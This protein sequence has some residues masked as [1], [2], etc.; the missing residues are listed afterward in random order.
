MVG[1]RDTPPSIN[2][3]PDYST[4]ARGNHD[5]NK[6][7]ATGIISKDDNYIKMLARECWDSSTN[8]LNAG[9][10]IAWNDS[11]RAFQGQHT[12]NSKYLSTDYRYRSR[13]FRPKTRSM[14]RKAEA[15]A[16][17]AFFGNEDV[18]SITPTD[19]DNPLQRASA[20]ILKSLVQYRLTKTIPW[21]LTLV[22]GRQDAEVMGIAIAKAYW[23]FA[24]KYSSTI[25]KPQIDLLTGQPMVDPE[26]GEPIEDLYDVFETQ[27]DH[28]WIDLL[29]P[30]N[31]RFDPGADWRNPIATSPY[32]IEVIP[33]YITDVKQKIK[34]GEWLPV[35]DGSLHNA[36]DLDDDVTRRS[37]EYGRVPGKDHDAWKPR[38][39]D[40]CWIRENIIR[41]DG[42]EM[43]CYSLASAGELL[44]KPRPVKEVYLHGIRPYVCGFVIPEAHKTY[45]TSK[46]ELVKDLQRQAN[47][48][49]NLRLDNVK[50]ALNP[51]QIVRDGKGIDP[52]DVRNFQPGKVI[53]A[54]DPEADIRWD[55]PPDVTASSYQEQNAIDID[56]DGL[57]GDISNASIQGNQ[58]VYEAVGNMTM[59]QGSASQIGEYEQRTWAETFVEPLLTQLV[60]LEQAYE[61][62]A[63]IIANAGR[64]AQLLQK[65]GMNQVTDEMLQQELTVK[66][67]VGLGAT[68]PQM[69]LKNFMIASEAVGKM[70]GPAAAMNANPQEV[71]KEVFGLCGYKD[72][73][74]F[75]M[76][77][78]D[79][80]ASM[81][82]IAANS[83]KG[84]NPHEQMLAQQAEA[85]RQQMDHQATMEEMNMKYG[86][87]AKKMAF[88]ENLKEREFHRDT[89]LQTNKLNLD[90]QAR[91]QNQSAI[92]N[93]KASQRKQLLDHE[94]RLKHGVT[95]ENTEEEVKEIA[96]ALK[97]LTQHLAASH[98]NHMQQSSE[99]SKI[100]HQLLGHN[101][102]HSKNLS[103]A[104][105]DL[106][107]AHKAT[108]KTRAIRDPLTGKVTGSESYA[109]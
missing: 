24:E 19:D 60:K 2:D 77:G 101:V 75:F 92:M 32:T 30:E 23:K 98:Q 33:M 1:T 64:E 31:F 45:P 93:D 65:F 52:T 74:R 104:I 34:S 85:Q 26:T 46:V 91:I 35:S 27:T 47:D 11:L 67:N 66:V 71:I 94:I 58:K 4:L 61:T 38:D 68:N 48:V 62:D 84:N 88:E 87:E 70:F 5:Q 59:L 29:A 56:F 90:H 22:G 37:R 102:Q 86:L 107:K 76:P 44:S 9:R 55:R 57:T 82:Q 108:R 40:I 6:F 21:F 97:G 54:K 10:R 100:L 49:V 106:A 53:M 25:K 18:C 69:K 109:E 28:P 16:A 41:I 15:Q 17:A 20:A 78:A 63:V 83:G 96:E 36:T 8:W 99:H 73:D 43:H 80:H 105:H 72:G 42:E 95:P 81:Q 50:L 7:L 51:R 103:G 39:Y 12:T 89:A 3:A 14:V 13:L 79:I